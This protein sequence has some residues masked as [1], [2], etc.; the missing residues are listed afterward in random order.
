MSEKNLSKEIKVKKPQDEDGDQNFIKK[1]ET[2]IE[3]QEKEEEAGI[4][5]V[6]NR[7][8]TGLQNAAN[9]LKSIIFPEVTQQRNL[10]RET[11]GI[12]IEEDKGIS[13]EDMWDKRPDE[14]KKMAENVFETTGMKS[15]VWQLKAKRLK[16]KKERDREGAEAA[17][18]SKTA[19]PRQG[20]VAK[21]KNL[22]LDRS[23]AFDDSK[24]GG[25]LR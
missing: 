24:G 9:K 21:L 10:D 3:N 20:Y 11:G 22:K 18:A 12:E 13:E 23:T 14:I 8:L 15:R 6:T 5:G 17:A 1:D 16:E 2:Q 4:E 7:L 25:M 19:N